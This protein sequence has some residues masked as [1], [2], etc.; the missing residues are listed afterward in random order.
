MWTWMMKAKIIFDLGEPD[1]IVYIKQCIKARQMALAL[2]EV[3][4]ILGEDA[5]GKLLERFLE[6]L[7][8]YEIHL[9]ELSV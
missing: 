6:I 9:N 5:S 8:N 7:D 4:E 3:S 2:S 1:D